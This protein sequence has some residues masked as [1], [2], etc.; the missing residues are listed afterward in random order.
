MSKHIITAYDILEDTPVTEFPPNA[1]Q[2]HLQTLYDRSAVNPNDTTFIDWI[3]YWQVG[4][5]LWAGKLPQSLFQF[6]TVDESLKDIKAYFEAESYQNNVPESYEWD[7]VEDDEVLVLEN[8]LKMVW[9]TNEFINGG[10][11]FENP[12]GGHWCPY[13]QKILIHP[14]GCRNKI[15]KLFG[16]DVD[17]VFF[18][19]GAFRATWMED[20]QPVDPVELY[21]QGWRG[22]VV[23]EHGTL[24]PHLLKDLNSIVDGK[25]M[26]HN[27]LKDK[28]TNNKLKVYSNIQLPYL[29]SWSVDRSQANVLVEFKTHATELKKSH[30]CQAIL[31]TLAEVDYD[32]D[33][34]SVK[35]G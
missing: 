25:S 12:V 30:Y 18:N 35:H 8:L 22:S 14:G 34:L 27:K 17:I 3:S 21:Q 2:M 32:N 13:K 15:I 5:W 10:Y 20:L 33:Y 26:W 1:E 11:K 7:K 6:D 16:D 31:C 23:P 28:L 24:I 4:E 19:T 9:L 29:Q